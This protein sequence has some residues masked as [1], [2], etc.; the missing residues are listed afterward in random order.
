MA[1]GPSINRISR[2]LL[3]LAL[4]AQSLLAL[5]APSAAM[6][7]V[8]N[9]ELRFSPYVGTLSADTPANSLP[10]RLVI[11][12]NGIPITDELEPARELTLGPVSN[13]PTAVLWLP[14]HQNDRYLRERDN[15]LQLRFIPDELQRPYTAWSEWNGVSDRTIESEERL[16][17]GSVRL[18]STNIVELEVDQRQHRG[19]LLIE[20]RFDAPWVK[21]AP[22]QSQPAITSL[23]SDDETTLRQLVQER[24]RLFLND[25]PAAYAA[26][27]RNAGIDVAALQQNRCLE[28]LKESGMTLGDT[29]GHGVRLRSTGGPVVVAEGASGALFPH[30]FPA[31]FGE[32]LN[33]GQTICITAALAAALPRWMLFVRSA[34]GRWQSLD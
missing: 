13:R 23:S 29:D 34:D 2:P 3:G 6:A 31:G 17:D 5:C 27:P 9:R 26:M 15:R 33:L 24:R 12:L 25:L 22:W 8:I 19:E 4:T 10:G 21:A 32:Q 28:Q 7:E 30:T 1:T 20:R 16:S 11:Q 18:T 14:L